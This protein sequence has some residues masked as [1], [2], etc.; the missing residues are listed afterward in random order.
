MLAMTCAP[1]HTRCSNTISKD[2]NAINA[3][4]IDK[5]C[6]IL[7]GDKQGV[8]SAGD[9]ALMNGRL[10]FIEE[11]NLAGHKFGLGKNLAG[12]K[13]WLGDLDSNQD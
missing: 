6:A 9:G 7:H 8:V 10:N 13:I 2:C 3:I 1:K 4:I 11:P 5:I 12:V